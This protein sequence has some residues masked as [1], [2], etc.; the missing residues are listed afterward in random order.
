MARKPAEQLAAL[1]WTGLAVPRCGIHVFVQA[2]GDRHCFYHLVVLLRTFGMRTK[3]SQQLRS[4]V[5]R[6]RGRG[7]RLLIGGVVRDEVV[8]ERAVHLQN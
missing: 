1:A 5:H 4:G 7:R 6:G 8:V 2:S 3:C